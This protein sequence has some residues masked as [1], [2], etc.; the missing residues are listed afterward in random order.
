M[1]TRVPILFEFN[2]GKVNS[3]TKQQRFNIYRIFEG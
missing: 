1:L 3:A 2:I